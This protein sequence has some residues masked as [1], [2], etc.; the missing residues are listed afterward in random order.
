MK[1]PRVIDQEAAN[2]IP[3]LL[4]QEVSTQ[5][6]AA[7]EGGKKK[8]KSARKTWGHPLLNQLPLQTHGPEREQKKSV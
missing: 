3:A 7:G 8:Q 2:L 1:D 5:V 6:G 4:D